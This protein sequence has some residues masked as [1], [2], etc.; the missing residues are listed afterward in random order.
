MRPLVRFAII[1]A[2]VAAAFGARA[3]SRAT[4]SASDALMPVPV[5]AEELPEEPIPPTYE[6]TAPGL[7]RLV[8]VGAGA[9]IPCKA[10]A[11]IRAEILCRS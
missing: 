2:V 6:T 8:A 5:L 9:C 7:P 1:A 4:Q 3:L 10:M 11:P